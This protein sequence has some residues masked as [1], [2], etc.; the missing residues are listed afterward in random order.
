[1]KRMNE[2]AYRTRVPFCC[3]GMTRNVK[4]GPESTIWM[5]DPS[6]KSTYLLMYYRHTWGYIDRTPCHGSDQSQ[7]VERV[8]LETLY[9]TWRRCLILTMPAKVAMTPRMPLKLTLTK[10]SDSL[11][12]MKKKSPRKGRRIR[13]SLEMTL[14]G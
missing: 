4:R 13:G 1:M 14:R 3:F 6:G 11:P 8:W 12:L 5:V 9:W 2:K 7:F 10:I